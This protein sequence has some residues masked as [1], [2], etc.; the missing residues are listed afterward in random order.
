MSR[1][2]SKSDILEESAKLLKEKG[3]FPAVAHCSYFR[4]FLLIQHIWYCKLH[5]TESDISTSTLSGGSHSILINEI[6]LQIRNSGRP[7]ALDNSRLFNTQIGE[8]KRL[9]II[10][11]YKD[12]DFSFDKCCR[13]IELSDSI[14]PILKAI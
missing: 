7:N 4:C 2:Q 8:L 6:Y 12:E 10:A 1:F 14:V 9:R 13:S 11:D 5:K 3:L